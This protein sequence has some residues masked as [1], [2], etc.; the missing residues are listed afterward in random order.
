VA[1]V[2]GMKGSPFL[3][4]LHRAQVTPGTADIGESPRD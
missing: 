3:F 2:V 1:G 4:R